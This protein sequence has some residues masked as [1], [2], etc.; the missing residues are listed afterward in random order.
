M[1]GESSEE[2]TCDDLEGKQR[3]KAALHYTIGQICTGVKDV[4]FTKEFIATLT[5][6]A[7]KECE[8]LSTDLEL[9]AKH[10][11]RTTVSIDD[12]KLFCR[13]NPDLLQLI[14]KKSEQ[15]KADKDEV[16]KR[17]KGKAKAAV[18]DDED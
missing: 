3:L 17:S 7:F 12:V 15:L 10:A 5:E 13:R 4:T 16:K 11:K 1:A 8:A 18:I 6:T 2:E 14:S 9:F